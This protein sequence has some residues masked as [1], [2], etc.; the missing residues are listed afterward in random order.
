MENR[1]YESYLIDLE[2]TDKVV[3]GHLYNLSV[4]EKWCEQMQ[5]EKE[6]ITRN[7]ILS[8][9]Q[10]MQHN[11]FKIGSQ[12]VILNS[13]EK[14]FDFLRKEQVITQNPIKGFRVRNDVKKV[15]KDPL[16]EVEL[17]QLYKDYEQYINAKP[18][19]AFYP[20]RDSVNLRMKL[21]LSLIV[22]QGLHTGELD[23]LTIQ[24]VNPSEGTIY[25]PSLTKSDSRVIEL[26]PCQIIPFYEYLNSLPPSQEKL[27]KE[28]IQASNYYIIQELKGI[29]PIVRNVQ[30]LRQSVLINWIKQYG[31]YKA[32]YMIGHRYVS[33]TEKYEIQDTTDLA[34]LM[35]TTHLFG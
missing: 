8:Y 3:H 5:V 29:N 13:L 10:F 12:N 19:H 1:K 26:N 31:V 34:E 25:I 11:E 15:V 6:F 4:F 9:V 21:V 14:Y 35:E 16:S 22:F 18:K 27:F 28:N 23:K 17:M 7:G 20:Q 2:H 30:H 24:D 32:K 33:S